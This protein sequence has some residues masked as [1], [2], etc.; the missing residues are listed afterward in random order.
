M[1][2]ANLNENPEGKL[3]TWTQVRKL[4]RWAG[5][6]KIQSDFH[7]LNHKTQ[8]VK[9]RLIRE[10]CK[11]INQ[12]SGKLGH[13]WSYSCLTVPLVNPLAESVLLLF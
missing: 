10:K 4:G 5:R 6:I 9:R 2:I 3:F 11:D 8:H 13:S 7:R 12:R 1:F